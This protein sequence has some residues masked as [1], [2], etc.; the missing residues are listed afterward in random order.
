MDKSRKPESEAA[1][2]LRVADRSSQPSVPHELT[3]T[4][5]LPT[6]GVESGP[7]RRVGSH[8]DT[9]TEALPSSP[10]EVGDVINGK[11]RVEGIIGEGGVGVVVAAQHLE[12]D[13][14][15]AIKFLKTD[16]AHN[17]ALVARFAREA[18]AAVSI[19]SEHVARIMDVGL[20]KSPRLQGVDG[21][22][23]IVMEHLE[24]TDLGTAIQLYGVFPIADTAEYALHA[25]EALAMA[26]ATGII[27]RD[28]KPDNLFLAA[29]AHTPGMKTLKVLD[30]GISKAALT[31]SVFRQDIPVI[32]T[33]HLMGTPLYMAP[34]QVRVTAE[35]DA[36]SDIWSLGMVLY[37]MLTGR[38]AWT[39]SSITELCAAILEKEAAPIRTLRADVPEGL[40]QVVE[41]CLRKEPDQRF[42]NVGELANALFPYAPKRA[43]SSAEKAVGVLRASGV[44]GEALRFVSTA[45]PPSG[46]ALEAAIETSRA[47]TLGSFVV[48]KEA[49]APPEVSVVPPTRRRSGWP[50]VA[51][52]AV[53]VGTAVG[54][55]LWLR[56]SKPLAA[57]PSA[58]VA[59]T[60]LPPPS[61][62]TS[63]PSPPKVTAPSLPQAAALPAVE[64]PKAESP[65][66]APA[67]ALQPISKKAEA[68]G[69]APQPVVKA[70]PAAVSKPSAP[71]ATA[72]KS[73]PTAN[74]P[75]LGY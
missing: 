35:A 65:P 30:F 19:R 5:T 40:A 71:K 49:K 64:S 32:Q 17:P 6:S 66:P 18:K 68:L 33:V 60:T 1:K 36:R 23:F 2:K 42:Q 69:T 73:S 44:G 39:G 10:V 43:R 74:D 57:T 20:W 38:T 21:V 11:Y 8:F 53:L 29:N 50:I 48:S 67:P 55:T 9:L 41:R 56:A 34:E 26:H 16:S 7:V 14:R 12:L 24:G 25:C 63:T 4:L 61:A 62:N 27:H 46:A 28:I 47:P 37:E 3:D 22:P 15:V 13:E 52:T 72:P 45:P 75:D 31:G 58:T 54:V 51:F 59:A 70:A